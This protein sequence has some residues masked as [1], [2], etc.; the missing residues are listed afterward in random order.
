MGEDEAVSQK[1]M[2][3]GAQAVAAVVLVGGLAA[4][5]WELK[6][7]QQAPYN[8]K[9]AVCSSTHTAKPSKRV[10]G[11]QLCTALNRPDLPALLGTPEEQAETADGS[12]SSFTPAGGTKITNPE[13]D[14]TLKTYSVQ[15][16]AS[17]DRLS[18]ARTAALLGD[19]AERQTVLGHP[20]VLYSDRTISISLIGGATAE[21]GPGGIAR[22]LLVARSA[23][24]G[25]GSFEVVIWR[26]DAVP[27]DDAALFR[28]AEQVLPTVPGWTAG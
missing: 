5:L 25:G 27:P 1:G 15:L 6:D 24:D 26:Q 22:R 11:A 17:Y 23:K 4:V 8:S 20:A 9:P 28:V 10:S 21:A 19:S 18:V 12:E 3:A 2:S 16:S 7:T 13:A 14:V